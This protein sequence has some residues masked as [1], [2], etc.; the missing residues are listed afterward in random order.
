MISTVCCTPLA[1]GLSLHSWTHLLCMC[2]DPFWSQI[3][4]PLQETMTKKSS[5]WWKKNVYF[6]S[7]WLK[8]RLN[9]CSVALQSCTDV[10]CWLSRYKMYNICVVFFEWLCS[11]D[12][13]LVSTGLIGQHVTEITKY[14]DGMQQERHQC[15]TRKGHPHQLHGFWDWLYMQGGWL[16]NG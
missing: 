2:M 12:N 4:Q 1:A 13:C 7:L 14:P 8:I 6:V 11:T 16:L 10:N 9:R 3:P 5:M 15:V